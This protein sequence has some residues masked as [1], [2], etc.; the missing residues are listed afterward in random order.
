MAMTR[1]MQEVAS[2]TAEE[3]LYVC[4]NDPV[5]I[6]P[7]HAMKEKNNW[8]NFIDNSSP[9]RCGNSSP[10]RYND[11][12]PARCT[13]EQ[14]NYQPLRS[15]TMDHTALYALPKGKESE[16]QDGEEIHANPAYG[17]LRRSQSAINPTMTHVTSSRL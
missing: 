7:D 5:Y 16:E 1:K 9:M 2:M 15:W 3:P 17:T 11:G 8:L 4:I 13:E 12:S 6:S 14:T 10:M